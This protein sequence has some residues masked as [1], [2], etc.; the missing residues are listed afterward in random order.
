MNLIL[1][2]YYIRTIVRTI[3]RTPNYVIFFKVLVLPRVLDF[4][5][6][7][8]PYLNPNPNPKIYPNL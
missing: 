6:N 8:N 5:D 4:L 3:V 1:V 7:S 2:T